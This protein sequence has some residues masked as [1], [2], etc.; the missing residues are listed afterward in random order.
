LGTPELRKKNTCKTCID[1][2]F[3]GEHAHVLCGKISVV[4]ENKKDKGIY[5]VSSNPTLHG[6]DTEYGTMVEHLECL[7]HV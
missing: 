4:Q 7:I 2:S 5:S 6:L 1:F 3:V